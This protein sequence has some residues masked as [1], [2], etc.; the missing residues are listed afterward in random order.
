MKNTRPQRISSLFHFFAVAVLGL[1]VPNL[2]WGV[3]VPFTG[4]ITNVTDVN[5]LFGG[6][7]VV[8]DTFTGSLTYGLSA[9]DS[10]PSP[11]LG[12]YQ[13]SQPQPTDQGNRHQYQ[14]QYADNRHH[15]PQHRCHGDG[16]Q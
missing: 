1:T 3:T 10:N 9:V 4:T 14:Q 15:R 16:V 6:I 2:S 12:V 11:S 13:L 7:V 5:N 8:G